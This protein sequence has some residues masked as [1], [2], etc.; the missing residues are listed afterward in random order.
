MIRDDPDW[1]GFH[2][3]L[4][5]AAAGD[6]AACRRL[7]RL[8]A[9]RL[10]SGSITRDE[11]AWLAD[12]LTGIA[13]SREDAAVTAPLRGRGRPAKT[14]EHVE[15]C[16]RVQALADEGTP[17]AHAYR[18][19]ASEAHKTTKAVERIHQRVRRELEEGEA[20]GRLIAETAALRTIN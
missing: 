6:P 2:L 7:Y 13:A 16:Q 19:V 11:A 8:V 3:A 5:D 9:D 15:T 14:A 12:L 4:S 10:R 18:I 17:L 20:E 1:L